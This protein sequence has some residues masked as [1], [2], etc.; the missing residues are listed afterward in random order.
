MGRNA[1]RQRERMDQRAKDPRG[2]A[3]GPSSFRFPGGDR[4]E[5]TSATATTQ[6]GPVVIAHLAKNKRET[7]RVALD[8]FAGVDLLDIRVMVDLTASSGV[9]VPTKK[10]VSVRIE[11]LGE[12][13]EALQAAHAKARSIG[14]IGGDL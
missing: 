13:I 2:V 11:M 9:A 7:L 14:L 3:G 1:A 8:R 5:D 4:E 10:G 6:G 12:L